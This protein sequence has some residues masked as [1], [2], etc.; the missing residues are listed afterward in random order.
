MEN[1]VEEEIVSRWLLSEKEQRTSN[2]GNGSRKRPRRAIEGA[3]HH[4]GTIENGETSG[5]NGTP[6]NSRVARKPAQRRSG[7]N[8]QQQTGS[9]NTSERVIELSDGG[10]L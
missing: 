2:E 10:D 6:K 9:L 3:A 5:T 8:Y 7:R 4:N 1:P